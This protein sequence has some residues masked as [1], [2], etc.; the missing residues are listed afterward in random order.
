M[1]QHVSTECHAPLPN[2]IKH[3]VNNVSTYNPTSPQRTGK[4]WSLE[5]MISETPGGGPNSEGT[6]FEVVAVTRLRLK[7]MKGQS[8]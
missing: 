7:N 6:Q 4:E 3:T 8:Y 1:K 5:D 2:C